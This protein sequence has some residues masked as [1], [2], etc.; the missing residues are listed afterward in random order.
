MSNTYRGFFGASTIAISLLLAAP[1]FAQDDVLSDQASDQESTT[2]S[3][4]IVVTAQRRE[5]NLQETAVTITALDSAALANQGIEDVQ[6]ISRAVP[7]LQL[8]PVTANPSNL[9]VGLRGGAEQVGGLIVSEPVVGI[10]IDDVYR[11]RLQ[12][13]NSQ[14]GDIERVEVLR[15]P[16]GTLYGRNNFSGALKLITKT[17]SASNQWL[18]ASVGL[19]SFD[20]MKVTASAG[21]GLTDNL[22]ASLSVLYRDV[23]D[24]YIYNRAQ[25]ETIGKEENLAIRGK[26]AFESGPFEATVSASYS[27]DDNDGYIAV[28]GLLPRVP[29]GKSDFVTTDDITPRFGNDP[30]VAEF[31]QDSFGR[32]ETIAISLNAAY[33]FG[34]AT[35]RSI[36][37]YVDLEDD[38]R[39]DLASGFETMPGVFSAGF[40]R[41]A[42]ASANQFTQEL[43]LQGDALDG[44][45][46]WI[47]GAFYFHESGNQSLTD[48]IPIFFLFDLDPTFLNMETD[49]YAVFAQVDYAITDRATITLGGR[50]SKDNK[51][52]DADIQSGFGAPNPRTAV[53][54]DETFDSFT[55]KFGLDYE[56]SD[57][58]FAYASVSKGFKAGGFNGLSIL[59]P[60]VLSAVYQPQTVWAY[61]AGLKSTFMDGNGRAN[62]TVF[63]NDIS[64]LQQTSLIGP[65]SFAVQNVGDAKVFGVEFELFVSPAEGF[66]VFANVGYQD[67]DYKVLNPASQAATAG[68]TDL[69]LVAD[70]TLQGGFTY[71]GNFNDDIVARLGIDGAYIGDS[72]VE[73][74]NSIQVKGYLRTNAF[75][76]LT[77]DDRQWELKFQVDN[78]TD[79]KNYVSGF[80]GTTSPGFTILKP[81]TFLVSL[82]YDM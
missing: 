71:E 78:L 82:S 39:W 42:I 24:G 19:G 68:A 69:P 79:E 53:S 74:T 45:L 67:G 49:S 66:D 15:G 30:Y 65:G 64:D 76:A 13:S 62:I 9:Q 18:N 21:G 77:T 34:G 59:N 38:W 33:D 10:Y 26:L 32:T 56:L 48:N 47:L 1:A 4:V 41:T 37:G 5:Q 46:N 63:R 36:T 12:G 57:D 8:L 70:W 6:G 61:E 23:G 54:L 72:F 44:S 11:A 80:V 51:K 20:E 25:D 2:R 43:Q 3:N 50:Y 28:A 55:P 75:F 60:F 58:L 27:K 22:G 29:T 31:P 81:R 7:N 40:D 52:F 73:V 14:L 17:P 35:L 16:Q